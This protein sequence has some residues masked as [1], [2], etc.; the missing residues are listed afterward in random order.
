MNRLAGSH[1]AAS[2]RA[3]GSTLDLL[4]PH[5]GEIS[6]HEMAAALSRINRFNGKPMA[7]GYSVAQHSVMG[8]EALLNERAA[9]MIAA[10]FLLHDGHEYLL[11]DWTKPTQDAI[12]AILNHSS[13]GGFSASDFVNAITALKERWD[14]AIYQALNLPAPNS[15]VA[16]IVRR[17]DL[18]M[19]AA[20]A[21]ALFPKGDQLYPLA[22]YPQP[23]LR[24]AIV[25]WGP[26]KAEE[27]FINL[28]IQ[29]IGQ[30]RIDACRLA[31]LTHISTPAKRR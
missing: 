1:A 24:G 6:I 14:W 2:F 9:P 17:T 19:L 18:L 8:A 7:G 31:H 22:K 21:R 5:P 29:L 27:R 28:A 16:A 30:D 4:A 11:G 23:K 15:H 13:N 25:P 20:E 10:F 26:I 12:A 3:D